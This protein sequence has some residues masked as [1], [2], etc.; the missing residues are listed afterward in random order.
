[1]GCLVCGGAIP[2]KR[3]DHRAKTCSE[4][5]SKQRR[6]DKYV[7]RTQAPQSPIVACIYCHEPLTELQQRRH[8][9]F[10]S[11]ECSS[12]LNR[13]AYKANNQPSSRVF[14]IPSA[15]VGAIGELLVAVDLLKRRYNVFRAVSPSAD[16]D[17]VIVADKT[18]Y[19][20][21]VTTGYKSPT[22][23]LYY[24]PHDPQKYDVIAVLVG[25]EIH[26]VGELPAA[27]R[28]RKLE[29]FVI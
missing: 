5:C 6:R 16:C 4:Q 20:V 12:R 10:C 23:K 9:K 17:I 27:T 18:V 3:R 13:N 15:T 22:G 26:Y 1:M 29:R 14:D 28:R 2:F 8:S 25:D 21:E 19:R 7:A 11:R 24:P